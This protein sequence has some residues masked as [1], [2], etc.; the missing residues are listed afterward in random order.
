MYWNVSYFYF[1]IPSLFVM[2]A[3]HK[4]IAEKDYIGRLG[5]AQYFIRV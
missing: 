1:P 5:K 4:K 2:R 3:A